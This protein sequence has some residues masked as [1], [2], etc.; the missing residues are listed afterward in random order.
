M[1]EGIGHSHY[2]MPG[3]DVRSELI[4]VFSLADAISFHPSQIGTEH[5]KKAI[6]ELKVKAQAMK[7]EKDA[8]LASQN[9]TTSPGVLE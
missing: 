9:T 8:Q 6:A 2:L 3:R 4:I 1:S 7:A 5:A